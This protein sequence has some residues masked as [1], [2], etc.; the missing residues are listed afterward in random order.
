MES[1]DVKA[2]AP[3]AHARLG[4]EARSLRRV[5]WSLTAIL[6]VSLAMNL[7]LSLRISELNKP[8]R[9][10]PEPALPVGASVPPA[11]VL[12][13]EG[14]PALLSYEG[15]ARPFVLY[16]F[17]PQCSWCSR[18]LA[19]LRA[20]VSQKRDAYQFVGLSLREDGLK[21]YLAANGLDIPVYTA[22]AEETMREYRLG[23]TPQ[24]I[25]VSPGGKVLQN[26]V[27]AYGGA[28]QADVEKFFGV[29]LPGLAP[30]EQ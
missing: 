3:A 1:L 23:N 20:L 17:T 25:V 4:D 21:E 16:V 18:N 26:W 29:R 10:E 12:D 14:R 2:Q 22:P 7:W 8:K 30:A 6:A 24:M 28:K 13:I 19:N 9:S 11:K 27:G 5:V 15:A